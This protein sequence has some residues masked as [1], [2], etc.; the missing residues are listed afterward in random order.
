MA[1][2]RDSFD[3][4]EP[5]RTPTPVVAG[6]GDRPWIG[7]Q[8]DCAGVYVRVNRNAAGTGYLARCPRCGA[9]VRFRVGTGGTDQRFFRV[10]C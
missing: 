6:G 1:D 4:D 5:G 10:R 3:R 9:A 7:V 8:F 2:S